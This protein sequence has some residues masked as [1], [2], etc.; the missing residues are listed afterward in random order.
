MDEVSQ[1]LFDALYDSLD[2]NTKCLI[3]MKETSP[4]DYHRKLIRQLIEQNE[5]ILAKTK[6]F[7]SKL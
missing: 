3:T 1:L 6:N 4:V 7:H 2:S 5:I